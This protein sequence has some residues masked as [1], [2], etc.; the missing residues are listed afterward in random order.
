MELTKTLQ[1]RKATIVITISY[2]REILNLDGDKFEG[3]NINKLVKATL[4][5]GGK[6]IETATEQFIRPIN[7]E[8]GQFGSRNITASVVTEILEAIKEMHR[9]MSKSFEVVE[10]ATSEA[11]VEK[12]KAILNEVVGRTEILNDN[13]EQAWRTIYND[14]NNEGGEGYVPSRATLEDVEWANKLISG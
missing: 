7:A 9:E 12:A 8:K 3:K 13:E 11:K 5:M 2:D 1:I 14:L 10:I 6:L 4:S